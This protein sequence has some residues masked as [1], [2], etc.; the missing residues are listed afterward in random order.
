MMTGALQRERVLVVEDDD[1]TAAVVIAAVS[2][3]GDGVDARADFEADRVASLAQAIERLQREPFAAVLLDLSL[4]DSSGLATLDALLDLDLDCAIIVLT[5]L[6]DSAVALEAV[7][8]GAQDYLFKGRVDPTLILRSLLYA[9]GRHRAEAQLRHAQQMEALGR[10]AGGVAH[11]FNNLLTIVIGN[12]EALEHGLL[13]PSDVPTAI[14]EIRQAARR[15]AELTQRLLALGRQQQLQPRVIDVGDAVGA[16]EPMLRRLVGGDTVF[17]LVTSGGTRGVKV[18][19]T[20]LEQLVLNLVL[21]AREAVRAGGR[22]TIEVSPIDVR[23]GEAWKPRLRS[24]RYIGLTVRDDGEGIPPEV[25]ARLYEPFI[26]TK[27]PGRGAGLG[28]SIVYGIVQQSEGALRCDSSLGRGTTFTVAFPEATEPSSVAA[29][30][31]ETAPDAAQ[32]ELILLVEDEQAVRSLTRRILERAGYAVL[33][34]SSGEEA[35]ALFARDGGRVRLILTDVMMPGLRGPELVVELERQRPGLPVVFMSGYAD[36]ELLRR[37]AF[38][39]HV[40]FLKKPF[41]HLELL[42]L[43]REHLQRARAA[44]PRAIA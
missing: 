26:S 23:E 35:L 6:D 33:D 5:A 44:E 11:D 18:D 39:H 34:A 8:H 38:P 1:V 30:L 40:G 37:G 21:N 43:V 27:A 32:G 31:I 42:A 7:R 14:G 12:A 41:T 19:P 20:Q 13:E 36:D 10:L 16:M 22:I 28:L 15:A 3:G 4:P 24:G 2:G 9:I 25:Q 17:T 29:P